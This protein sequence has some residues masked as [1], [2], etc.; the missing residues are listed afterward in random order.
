MLVGI[1]LLW[2]EP[3]SSAGG[4]SSIYA[5]ISKTHSAF[6]LNMQTRLIKGLFISPSENKANKR[7]NHEKVVDVT[8]PVEPL[9]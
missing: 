2:K 9:K 8:T 4:R 5:K 6:Q 1:F 3:H 7:E